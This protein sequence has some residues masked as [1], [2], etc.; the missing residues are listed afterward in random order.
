[1]YISK[2]YNSA[3][4]DKQIILKQNMYIDSFYTMKCHIK[5]YFN[6][7]KILHLTESY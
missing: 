2:M 7:C 5:L 4:N 1:M 6:A 3:I